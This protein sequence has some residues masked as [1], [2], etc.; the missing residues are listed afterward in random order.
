MPETSNFLLFFF[1]RKVYKPQIYPII[2]SYTN[3]HGNINKMVKYIVITTSTEDSDCDNEISENFQTL[4]DA[5]SYV[6]TQRDNDLEEY[7]N[8]NYGL[9]PLEWSH[10]GSEWSFDD[11]DFETLR[12]I[13]RIG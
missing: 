4:D 5:K 6:S 1:L 13:K 7:G 11:E 3:K 9:E 2:K 8:D 12:I 10:N